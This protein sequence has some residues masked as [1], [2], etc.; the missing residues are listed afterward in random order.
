[1]DPLIAIALAATPESPQTKADGFE[2]CHPLFKG[3][4]G[5][6]HRVTNFPMRHST[7]HIELVEQYKKLGFELATTW[8]CKEMR[9]RETSTVNETFT[10]SDIQC[11]GGYTL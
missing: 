1:M 3:L 11:S 9:A 5:R 7:S 2:L 8:S 10:Y 6:W 4:T